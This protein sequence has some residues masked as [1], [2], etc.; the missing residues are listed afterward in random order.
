M[1]AIDRQGQ[2]AAHADIVERLALM[3]RCDEEAVV[4][5]D[6]RHR[7]LVAE[8]AN[9]LV[10]RRGWQPSELDRGAVAADRVKTRR[11]LR[12]QDADDAVKMRQSLM[13][14]VGVT[15]ALDG[16]ARLVADQLEG[17]R[18]QYVLLVP[19]RVLIEDLFLV[20]PG[21]R[22]GECREECVGW[23]LQPERD[24]QRIGGLDLVDHDVEALAGASDP[25][26]WIDDLFP[27]RADV[28]RG[29]PGSIMKFDA[30]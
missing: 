6:G 4:L 10:A 29:Q 9:Q 19:A 1:P 2:S 24:G 11:L 27:A 18:A 30:V 21:E 26:W 3:V 15:L 16:L 20:N 12:C 28:V 17:A 25:L 8:R 14:V 23:E 22:I 7:D 13:M 5:V